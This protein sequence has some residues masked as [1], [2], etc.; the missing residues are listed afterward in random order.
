[1][2]LLVILVMRETVKME[3]ITS[4]SIETKFIEIGHRM[5]EVNNILKKLSSQNF[6]IEFIFE[7]KEVCGIQVLY[8]LKPKIQNVYDLIA[9]EENNHSCIFFFLRKK[10]QNSEKGYYFKVGN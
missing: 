1:M 8:D 5:I 10:S 9:I 4:R 7:T 6:P 2:I 3:L